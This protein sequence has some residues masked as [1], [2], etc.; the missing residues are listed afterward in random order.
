M[1]DDPFFE[2]LRNEARTLRYEADAAVYTRLSARVRE[3]ITAPV[4][5]SQLLAQWFRPL[6]ASVAAIALTASIGITWYQQT[7]EPVSV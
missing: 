6:I 2:R 1:T 7:H 3:R 5:V 4:T